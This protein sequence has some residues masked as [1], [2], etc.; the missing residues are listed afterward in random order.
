MAQV[1]GGYFSVA[2]NAGSSGANQLVA[3]VPGAKIRVIAMMLVA[4]GTVSA[5][6][7]SGAGGTALTGVHS[8]VAAGGWVWPEIRNGWCQTAA[9]T[10]LNLELSTGVNVDGILVYEEVYN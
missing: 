6:L 1:G 7:E 10:L 9:N 2:I 8:M 5:R 3:A 4:R